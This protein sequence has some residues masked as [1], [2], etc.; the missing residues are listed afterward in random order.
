MNDHQGEA[1]IYSGTN[2]ATEKKLLAGDGAA[3]DYFGASVSMSSDGTKVIVG[4]YRKQ[5]G[6]NAEQGEG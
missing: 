2:Y 4:A 1:Y 5:V 6:A 3:N